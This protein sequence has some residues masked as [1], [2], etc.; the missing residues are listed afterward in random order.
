[1][2]SEK[3]ATFKST[4]EPKQAKI[5]TLNGKTR[6]IVILNQ[7]VNQNWKTMLL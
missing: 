2:E 1:M 7:L 5:V 4:F 3:I 6:E